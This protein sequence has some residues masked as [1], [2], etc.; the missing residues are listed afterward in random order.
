[1]NGSGANRIA[2]YLNSLGVKTRNGREWSDKRILSMIKNEKYKGDAIMGKSVK[3]LGEK[4]NNSKGEYGPRYIIEDSHKGIVSKEIWEKAQHI[5]RERGKNNNRDPITHTFTGL[6]ECGCCGKHYVHKINNCTFKWRSD[7]WACHSYLKKGVNACDS[8]RIKDSVLKE[9][10]V[11]AYNEFI[12]RRPEG[13]TV[14]AMREVLEN[15]RRQEREL[16]ELAMQR[17]I[18]QDVY[19]EERKSIKTQIRTIN[20]K[21]S[22]RTAKRVPESELIPIT[23]FS[24]EIAK[25]ILTK[26]TVDHFTVTFEFYNGAKISRKYNNGQPGNKPGW[27]KNKEGA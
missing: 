11:D 7:I 4:L 20:E 3:R 6:I 14:L 10:F 21:I 18:P 25:K 13:N 17:L 5:M 12:E 9:K 16:A 24:S 22:E 26:V 8:S 27:N 19:E 2:E 15:L 1:M 23:E